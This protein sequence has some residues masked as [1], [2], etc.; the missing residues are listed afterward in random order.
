MQLDV[1]AIEP[2]VATPEQWALQTLD[3]YRP[4][5]TDLATSLGGTD[6]SPPTGGEIRWPR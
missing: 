1:P 3:A 6:D 4:L 2:A 5:F